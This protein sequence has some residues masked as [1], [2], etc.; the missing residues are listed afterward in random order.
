[1]K[2]YIHIYLPNNHKNPPKTLILNLSSEQVN[3]Y[4]LE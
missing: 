1:M 4:T 3:S 2:L